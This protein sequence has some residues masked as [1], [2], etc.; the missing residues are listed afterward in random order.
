[1]TPFLKFQGFCCFFYF[2]FQLFYHFKHISFKWFFNSFCLFFLSSIFIFSINLFGWIGFRRGDSIFFHFLILWTFTIVFR[3][4]LSKN[5]QRRSNFGTQ[6]ETMKKGTFKQSWWS[7]DFI[8]D[9][10]M[11]VVSVWVKEN[12][13]VFKNKNV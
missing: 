4:E 1:M 3:G 2:L 12:I 9:N 13:K 11:I 8:N 7:G 5:S 10:W 6:R